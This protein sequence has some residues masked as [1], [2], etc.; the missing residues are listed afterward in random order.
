M[1]VYG[2]VTVHYVSSSGC[3]SCSFIFS[4]VID[5]LYSF[6]LLQALVLHYFTS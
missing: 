5:V 1:A 4:F 6:L 3:R 2:C